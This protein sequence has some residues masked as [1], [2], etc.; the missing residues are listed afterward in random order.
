MS[1]TVSIQR[2]T[3]PRVDFGLIDDS[4]GG[5]HPWLWAT[6]LPYRAMTAPL[7]GAVMPENPRT[8]LTRDEHGTIHG[9]FEHALGYFA[10]LQSFLTYSFGWTRHDKG[11]IWWLD[12][13]APADDA[14]FTL[15]RNVWLADGLLE[16]Y[17]S[18]CVQHPEID[19]FDAFNPHVDRQPI[20]LSDQWNDRLRTTRDETD[21]DDLSFRPDQMHLHG[22]EHIGGPSTGRSDAKLLGVDASSHSAVLVSETVAGWYA[23]L[24]HYGS[25]LPALPGGR[26]WRVDVHVKPIGFVGTYRRSRNSGLWFSGRHA[27]HSAGN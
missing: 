9:D 27:H 5:Q 20:T 10:S 7:S 18:W 3:R 22:G 8:L 14:R 26:S 17:L 11:L 21:G 13:G 15:I 16:S 12:Q 25:E 19:V 2:I 24:T 6:G 23:A 1:A 4:L